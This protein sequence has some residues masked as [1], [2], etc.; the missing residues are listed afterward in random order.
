M[1]RTVMDDPECDDVT[2][3]TSPPPFS[4]NIIT[5]QLM[6]YDCRILQS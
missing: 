4:L 2:P 6:A 1:N 5:S 3:V